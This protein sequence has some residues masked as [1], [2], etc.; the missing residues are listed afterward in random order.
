MPHPELGRPAEE[1]KSPLTKA[2]KT[3]SLPRQLPSNDPILMALK[4]NKGQRPSRHFS[5][6][7]SPTSPED[8]FSTSASEDA[9]SP[10][11]GDAMSPRHNDAMSPHHNEYRSPLSGE[12]EPHPRV[13]EDRMAHRAVRERKEAGGNLEELSPR[14]RHRK[15]DESEFKCY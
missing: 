2:Q 8:V 7:S 1:R 10:R 3:K 12:K 5:D 15:P 9:M 6:L 13:E 11:H 14:S 4:G